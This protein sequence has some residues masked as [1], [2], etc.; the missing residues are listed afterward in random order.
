VQ[1]YATSLVKAAKRIKS[2][3]PDNVLIWKFI[4]NLK[5]VLHAHWVEDYNK[6]TSFNNVVHHFTEYKQ[7]VALHT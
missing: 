3:I 6:L 4:T 1:L 5:L 7:G 2:G